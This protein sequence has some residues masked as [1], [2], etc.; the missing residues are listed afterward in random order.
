VIQ[1]AIAL[2]IALLAAGCVSSQ[3]LGPP[4]AGRE[5]VISCGYFGWYM[6]YDR[7]YEVCP[8]GFKVVSQ[9]E[10]SYRKELH[11][12]CKPPAAPAA[13]R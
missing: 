9:L 11:V 3:Q 6:C 1:T 4:A 10:P 2:S 8:G 5:Y 12:A 13:N 7:A